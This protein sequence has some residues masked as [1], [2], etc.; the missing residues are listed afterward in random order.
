LPCR[1]PLV[2]SHDLVHIRK[3]LRMED[4]AH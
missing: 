2:I 3:D 4:E 1:N